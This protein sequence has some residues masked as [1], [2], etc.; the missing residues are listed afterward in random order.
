MQGKCE[1]A[2]RKGRKFMPLQLKRILRNGGINFCPF[3]A[4]EFHIHLPVL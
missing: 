2:L 1:A 3:L 4:A